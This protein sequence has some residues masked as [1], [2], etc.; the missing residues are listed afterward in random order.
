M[1][2]FF[3]RLSQ[4]IDNENLSVRKF[5]REIS[6]TQGLIAK[7]IARDTNVG[8]D[9]VCRIVEKFPQYNPEWL[10]AGK[11]P[12]LRTGRGH[13]PTAPGAGARHIPLVTES[14]AAGFG[15][16]GFSIHERDVKEYYVIP[17]FH[18]LDIDFMI[19]IHGSSMY[20]KYSSGDVV[21]CT[22]LR[23]RRFIQWNKA[24]VIASRGQGIL[25]KRILQSDRKN[26]IRA[27][28][29]NK[30]YPPFDIPLSDIA[31]I[32]LVVGVIR[33]E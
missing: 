8:S 3:D 30:R 5:E 10:L 22:I 25:C 20:P 23:D 13:A 2:T 31:G 19:E 21:A 17:K 27:V 12:M 4:L 1:E 26:H 15:G 18:A 28:S 33:L 14:A 7:A 16:A 32:A 29:D 6:A 24:H 11:G 9:I